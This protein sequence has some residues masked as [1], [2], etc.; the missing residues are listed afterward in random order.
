MAHRI[1]CPH[2]GQTFDDVHFPVDYPGAC[3]A[4]G[5]QVGNAGVQNHFPGSQASDRFQFS[6]RKMFGVVTVVCVL[7]ALFALIMPAL[8][9]G[10]RGKR[11]NQCISHIKNI[12]LA[13]HN[14][15]DIHNRLPLA[16]TQPRTG[17]PGVAA[18]LNPAGYS[19]IVGLLPFMEEVQL[20]DEFQKANPGLQK[21]PFEASSKPEL[22]CN[23][24][25]LLKCSSDRGSEFVDTSESEYQTYTTPNGK[26]APARSTYVAFA[27]SH[28]ANDTG[29]A[30]PFESVNSNQF[31][32]NG[33]IPFPMAASDINQG[34]SLKAITDGTSKTMV[35]T[36][37]CELSYAAWIDGQATWV[38]GAWQGPSQVPS[39][40]GAADGF[41]GWPDNDKVSRTAL[42]LN[43]DK[44]ANEVYLSASRFGAGHDRRWG[45]S[46]EHTGG[47]VNHVFADGHVISITPDI[48]RN[49]YLRMISRDGGD[50]FGVNDF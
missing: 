36:E 1:T 43:P 35:L 2:C 31:D 18:G 7:L 8:Q 16:S 5:G 20:W 39:E 24:M 4:C 12:G 19:W 40:T 28:F 37:T 42:G 3:P 41:L 25:S 46:S 10:H 44:N 13:L 21:L 26:F 9:Y 38:V 29:L 23:W 22:A 50:Q 48:D 6:T 49:V 34:L 45:P 17:R 33:V 11:R 15:H 32:G 27:A 14:H 47:A 30:D